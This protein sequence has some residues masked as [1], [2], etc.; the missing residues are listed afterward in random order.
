MSVRNKCPDQVRYE[1]HP[2]VHEAIEAA[3]VERIDEIGI[4]DEALGHTARKAMPIATNSAL[5]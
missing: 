1:D 5:G 4:S 2:I 3:A